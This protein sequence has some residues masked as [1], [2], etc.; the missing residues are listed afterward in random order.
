MPGKLG[1]KFADIIN[2]KEKDSFERQEDYY[3]ALGQFLIWTF[4]KLGGTDKYRREFTYLTNPT[5]NADI[6]VKA[7]RVLSFLHHVP[8]LIDMD[9]GPVMKIYSMLLSGKNRHVESCTD[10]AKCEDA[11][12]DGLYDDNI[13]DTTK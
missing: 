6:Q 3:F 11:F 4:T 8:K 5:L 13:I 2:N 10:R 9:N 1:L 12:Y 7:R